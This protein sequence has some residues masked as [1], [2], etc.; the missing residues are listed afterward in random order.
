MTIHTRIFKE[1]SSS[2]EMPDQ[3]P[4]KRQDGNRLVVCLASFAFLLLALALCPFVG[5]AD[6][7]ID[8]LWNSENYAETDRQI[9][10]LL[11]LPRV[12][13]AA[14]AGAALSIAGVVYQATLRNDLAEPFSL[15]VAGGAALGAVL[16]MQVSF[17]SSYAASVPLLAFTGSI[18]AIFIVYTISMRRGGTLSPETLILAGVALNLFFGAII[19]VVQYLTDPYQTVQIIRWMMGGIP[20]VGKA[21]LFVG[22]AILLVSWL[23]LMTLSKQIDILTL[24][25][26][27]AF[28]LGVSVGKLRL[29]TLTI[30]SVLTAAVV[31]VAGPIGF[32]GLII[33]HIMRRIGGATHGYLL[34]AAPLAGGAFLV[35]CD[36][37]ARTLL[38]GTELPVGILTAALG[39][40]FFIWILWRK[41]K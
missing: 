29:I 25:E 15:G 3:S 13:F 30:G 38:D 20:V 33:P 37:L 17:L 24:G 40:P 21:Q 22:I 2:T 18:A 41:K 12:L 32:V 27:P 36:T 28:H 11:R 35:C 39:S 5:Y 9:F 6:V 26:F 14:L 23:T 8:I 1:I 16:G 7:G 34:I 31:S 10:F 19:L 4:A